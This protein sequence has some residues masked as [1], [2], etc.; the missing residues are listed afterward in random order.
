MS[1]GGEMNDYNV[2]EIPLEYQASQ[3]F[4]SAPERSQ[5]RLLVSPYVSPLCSSEPLN[6]SF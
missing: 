3:K 2:G 6:V 5:L 4:N 1:E